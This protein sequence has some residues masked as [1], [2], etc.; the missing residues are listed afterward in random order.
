MS[1]RPARFAVLT[2]AA[3]ELLAEAGM[4]G[5]THRAVDA[6]A[7]VPTGTSSVHFRTRKALI[8]AVVQ[9]LADLDQAEIEAS[10]LNPDIPDP[11]G[12]SAPALAATWLD[13]LPR[14]TAELL[15]HW[16]S[17]GRTRTLARYACL[18]EATH[19]PG[20]R[21]V[22]LHGAHFRVQA[23]DLLAHTGAPDAERRGRAL[24]AFIDGLAFNRLIGSGAL[25]APPPGTPESKRDLQ[26]TIE[27]ALR[28]VMSEHE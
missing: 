2:D 1:S 28:A 13:D 20:L 7:G 26:A 24:V 17:A 11:A 3:I 12:G 15:D 8:E 19:H 25:T 14:R 16:L 27:L 6:R 4:R 5:L 22:L 23:S 21:D 9:R 10:G 18:L